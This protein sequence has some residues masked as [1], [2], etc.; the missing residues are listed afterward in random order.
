MKKGR[1]S[2]DDINTHIVDTIEML[3]NNSDGNAS[4]NEKIDVETAQTIAELCKVAI[5][6]YKVKAQVLGIVSKTENM[7]AVRELAEASGLSDNEKLLK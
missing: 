4:D 6:G 3:K 1:I 5:D 7:S 2:I